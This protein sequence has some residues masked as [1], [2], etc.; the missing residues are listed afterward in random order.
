MRLFAAIAA[1]IAI[2]IPMMAQTMTIQPPPS[3]TAPATEARTFA[4]QSGGKLKVS[5]VNGDIAISAWDKN[6]V[7]LTAKFKST[8]NGEYPRIEADSNSSSLELIV[9][10][11]KEKE[12]QGG[13]CEMELKV[14]RR[15]VGNI[16]TVNGK[17]A[18]SN[19][20][21]EQKIATVNGNIAME[22]IGGSL[23]AST[24]NGGIQGELQKL[25]GDL[26]ISTVNGSIKVKL[27][28]PDGKFKASTVNGSVKLQN[29]S[30]KDLEINKGSTK[31]TFGSGRNNLTFSTVNG[32]ITVE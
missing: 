21:G 10:Y 26:K 32:S 23:K 28:D 11:P 8:G 6:E 12:N 24:V 13:S 5:N 16:S 1:S 19:L 22:N 7:A 18:L 3:A 31:A 25:E 9:K 4:L 29:H 27:I 30:A 17:V 2:A 14:P 15:I 20:Q